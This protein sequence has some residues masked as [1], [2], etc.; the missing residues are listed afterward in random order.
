MQCYGINSE[1]LAVTHC[2]CHCWKN[3][4]QKRLRKEL[5]DRRLLTTIIFCN[6]LRLE[7][8]QRDCDVCHKYV[9]S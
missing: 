4:E 8:E 5:Q 9:S 6:L 2:F 3:C 7:I 1:L